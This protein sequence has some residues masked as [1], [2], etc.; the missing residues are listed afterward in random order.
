MRKGFSLIELLVVIG[1]IGVL[2][3]VVAVAVSS[4]RRYADDTIRKATLNQIGQ[5][6]LASSCYAPDGGEGDYDF[7]T[8]FDQAVA[9]NPGITKLLAAAP[10][11][12]NSGS[13]TE[14]GYRYAYVS[15]GPHCALYANLENPDAKV[16]LPTLTGPTPGGGSGILKAAAKGPNG[17]DRYYQVSR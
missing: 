13:A 4:A 17:T 9:A 11:D 12:P 6:L 5:Y 10:K 2:A 3:T 15:A 16:D 1:I 14:S 8:L 7:K